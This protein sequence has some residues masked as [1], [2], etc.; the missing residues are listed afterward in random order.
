MNKDQANAHLFAA[1]MAND[2]AWVELALQFGAD[3]DVLGPE[4][5]RPLHSAVALP[6]EEKRAII[7][8]LLRKGASL[9]LQNP[10]EQTPLE[11]AQSLDEWDLSIWMATSKF[12]DE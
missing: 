10:A 3:P 4:G 9:S 2:A 12:S 8:L 5:G 6:G 1:I 11:L 7:E